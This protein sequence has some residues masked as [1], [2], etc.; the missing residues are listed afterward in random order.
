MNRISEN[1]K[2]VGGVYQITN[3]INNKIYIGSTKDLFERNSCHIRRSNQ[4]YHNEELYQEIREFGIENFTFTVIEIV[5]KEN[6]RLAKE[7][8]LIMQKQDEGAELYNNHL[9]VSKVYKFNKSDIRKMKKAHL[10]K[11]YISRKVNI[12]EAVNK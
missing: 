11:K 8:A 7:Q 5:E 2:G 10:G 1:L 9:R 6:I 4:P 3:L 12:K